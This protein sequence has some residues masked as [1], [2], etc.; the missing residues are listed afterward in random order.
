MLNHEPSWGCCRSASNCTFWPKHGGQVRMASRAALLSCRMHLYVCTYPEEITR[1][2]LC[3]SLCTCNAARLTRH[4][5][6]CSLQPGMANDRAAGSRLR[7][8]ITKKKKHRGKEKKHNHFLC[9]PL[10]K[11]HTRGNAIDATI[12]DITTRTTVYHSANRPI[13]PRY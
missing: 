6:H 9:H 12:H 2:F 8:K 7:Q 5:W 4:M 13:T 11:Q 1:H 10:R 3:H